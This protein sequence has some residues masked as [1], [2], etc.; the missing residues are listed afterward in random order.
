MDDKELTYR[1]N[2]HAFDWLYFDSEEMKI[3]GVVSEVGDFQLT[4]TAVDK[5]GNS[6]ESKIML[7]VME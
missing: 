4:I 5:S 2:Q 7:S 3:S 1:L 6:T